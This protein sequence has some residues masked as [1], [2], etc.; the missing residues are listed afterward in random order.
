MTE[1][2]G[3][4]PIVL[5]TVV[6]RYSHTAFGQ[7]CVEANLGPLRP[8]CRCFE[9]TQDDAP[10]EMAEAIL[11][12]NPGV[13]GLGAYIWNADTIRRLARLLKRLRP[14]LWVVVGGPET[15]SDTAEADYAADYLVRGEGEAAF[16]A[17]CVKLLKNAPPPG[18]MITP[19][20]CEL[21]AV[22]QPYAAYTDEDIAHRVLYVETSRGCLGRCA[23]CVSAREHKMRFFPLPP[24]F[25]AMG[26]LLAR[27]ARRFKFVD[28][29]F[30]ARQDRFHAV[31]E[32]FLERWLP[33]MELHLELHPELLSDAMVEMLARFPTRGLHLEV[34]V[35][36]LS[37]AT[38]EAVHRPQ[39]PD[40]ALAALHALRRNTGARIHAD[41]IAGLPGEGLAAFGEGFDRLLSTGIPEI[42]VGIL[43][44]LPGSPMDQAPPE[45]ALF[46]TEPPY[47]V[48]QTKELSFFTLQRLK[49][50][51]RHFDR[52]FNCGAFPRTM[53]RVF[54]T[55]SSPF[56]A[57]LLL[58]AETWEAT[59]KSW[60][61]SIETRAACLQC[62][63]EAHTSHD[64]EDIARVI[65][66]D[67]ARRPRNVPGADA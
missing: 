48:L 45:N 64:A 29:T 20:P 1:A 63:L 8:R 26:A 61:L 42:Q 3:E 33:G 65:A 39:S 10:A 17:L 47:E 40:R 23:F 43:K 41:L 5:A 67:I 62:Y 58:S 14:A 19:P 57:F 60:G 38:L 52:Y 54:A 36:S 59:G 66:G 30:N 4:T 27:G 28:R 21:N 34:G 11:A 31:L 35:Q 12:C 22:A 53:E 16:P 51:S 56:E 46:S 24:F 25:A 2:P 15:W 49:R 13:V 7:R 44:R 55:K 9:F 18:R 37:P 6:A 50:F 32:F